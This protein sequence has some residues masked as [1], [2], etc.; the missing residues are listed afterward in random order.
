[1][2]IALCDYSGH[3]FQVQLS[4]EL[5]RRGHDLLHLYFSEF[6]TPRG[7]LA[8]RSDD[9]PSLAIEG[10]SL[11]RPF[12]KY[13][14]LKRRFQEVRIGSRIAERIA[15]FSPDLTIGCNLPL[16]ALAR[17]AGQSRKRGVPFVFWQ[18]DIYSHAIARCLRSRHGALGSLVAAHYRALEGRLARTSDA[19]V[20]I[21]PEFADALEHG[22]G[23]DPHCIHSVENWAPLDEITPR[24]KDNG[25]S[26]RHGLTDR[27]VVLYSGTIGLKHD[28]T[29]LL[30]VARALR[31]RQR[32]SVVVVS[33]GP[34]ASWLAEQAASEG[35]PDLR[36]LPFQPFETYPEVLGSADIL[37][38]I[39][40][41]EAGAYSVPSKVLSYLCAGRAVA[42]S[43]PLENL[44]ARTVLAAGAG[45]VVPAA[46]PLRLSHEI[47]TLLR[48]PERRASYAAAGRLYAERSFEIAAIA[49]RFAEVLDAAL[50]VHRKR[51]PGLAGSPSRS[52]HSAGVDVIGGYRPDGAS[53]TTP[54]YRLTKSPAAV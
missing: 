51:D 13:A 2:R 17:V 14:F 27:D 47:E 42:L 11:G 45:V 3:P 22:F 38:S 37:V 23:V 41:G 49:D 54:D 31:D 5:A 35:L 9:P 46:T 48:E 34:G 40:D 44:A 43:A 39:L 29:R 7:R 19:V 12:A 32:T 50:D 10:V 52:G 6:Q 18:Q 33:E 8:V 30:E 1:M 24:A 20:V 4:R 16:D 26:R 15:R 53:I 28:P 36:V 25:W 21:A